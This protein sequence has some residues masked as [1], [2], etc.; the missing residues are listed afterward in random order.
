MDRER[1]APKAK[2]RELFIEELA[3]VHG[4]NPVR[5]LLDKVGCCD[6]TMACCEES[7][8]PCCA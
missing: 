6:T 4:G 8:D 1:E 3:E 7:P 5:D 2:I